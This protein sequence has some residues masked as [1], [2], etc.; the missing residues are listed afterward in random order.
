[1]IIYLWFQ[2]PR[3]VKKTLFG[4]IPP[5]SSN[6][7]GERIKH[8]VYYR[9][10]KGSFYESM[11][12]DVKFTAFLPSPGYKPPISLG[13]YIIYIFLTNINLKHIA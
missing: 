9:V 3:E 5:D 13:I 11:K 7:T 12:V 2:S 1:M 6:S 10:N 8:S 4:Y